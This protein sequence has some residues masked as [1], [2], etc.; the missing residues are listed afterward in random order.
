[1]TNKV[2][3][4][5]L[6]RLSTYSHCM[7]SQWKH[8]FGDAGNFWESQCRLRLVLSSLDCTHLCKL[9]LCILLYGSQSQAEVLSAFW[10]LS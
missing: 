3:P 1:M 9:R 6:Q 5:R 4:A 10:H 8:C 7:M 2:V